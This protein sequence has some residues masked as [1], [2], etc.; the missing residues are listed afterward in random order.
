M[1]ALA[2]DDKFF[3]DVVDAIL[4]MLPVDK[5]EVVG[6]GI[7]INGLITR[8][9]KGEEFVDVF[10]SAGQTIGE[11]D[12]GDAAQGFGDRVFTDNVQLAFVGE[13]IVFPQPVGQDFGENSV[14]AAAAAQFQGLG[15]RYW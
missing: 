5:M 10:V 7:T 6:L 4:G 15:V 14:A 9:T 13:A 12:I 8:K 2:L 3:G 1:G 11:L